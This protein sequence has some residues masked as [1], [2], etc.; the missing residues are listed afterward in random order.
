MS[1]KIA[2]QF[3]SKINNSSVLRVRPSKTFSKLC[4]YGCGHLLMHFQKC[5]FRKCHSRKCQNKTFLQ[6][7]QNGPNSHF[8]EYLKMTRT[9]ESVKIESVGVDAYCP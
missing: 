8:L 6:K 2:N 9:F 3:D 5:H 4:M 1:I 7:Y